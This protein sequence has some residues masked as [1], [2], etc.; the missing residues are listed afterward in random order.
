[1]S[2]FELVN[3]VLATGGPVAVIFVALRFG[4]DAVLRLL[5]GTVAV[6][7]HDAE[8]GER[9]LA[10]LRILR[11]KDTPQE[12]AHKELQSRDDATSGT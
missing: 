7:T 12:S 4:S 3:P 11:S 8:R 10:V 9:C 5:A 6:L 2:P 1:M